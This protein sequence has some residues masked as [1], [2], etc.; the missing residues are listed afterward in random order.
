MFLNY[1]F[2]GFNSYSREIGFISTSMR[3]SAYHFALPRFSDKND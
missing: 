2:Y 3:L 1:I